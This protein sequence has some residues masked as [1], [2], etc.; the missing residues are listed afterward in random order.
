MQWF[1]ELVTNAVGASYQTCYDSFLA[2]AQR[3]SALADSE[4]AA[5]HTASARRGGGMSTATVVAGGPT[6]RRLY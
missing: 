1:G 6:F 3:T 5:G 4:L 2:L